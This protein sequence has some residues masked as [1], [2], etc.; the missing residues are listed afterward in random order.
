M[1]VRI[2]LK[3]E[4]RAQRSASARVVELPV[5]VVEPAA[6]GAAPQAP[7]RVT[8]EELAQLLATV[9]APLTAL[10]A[11]LALW[12][13]GQDMG[14]ATRFFI[15]EGTFS[16]WQVWLGLAAAML[17]GVVRLN[18]MGRMGRPSSRERAAG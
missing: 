9:L 10:V 14:F 2:R 11:A 17:T 7:E 16:H 4:E 3:G 13:F 12:R 18:R 6:R 15:T 8:R 5:T 1:R